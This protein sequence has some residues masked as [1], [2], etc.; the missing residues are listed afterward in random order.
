MFGGFVYRSIAKNTESGFNL[1][2]YPEVNSYSCDTYGTSIT[3]LDLSNLDIF[4]SASSNAQG[5]AAALNF[6][7]AFA[8]CLKLT[9]VKL[10]AGPSMYVNKA[11]VPS[12]NFNNAFENC[13]SLNKF[14][15]FSG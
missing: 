14:P 13:I 5:S 11:G 12:I 7:Y 8:N 2:E 9:E 3:T 10:P 4:S 6:S 1:N 15:D